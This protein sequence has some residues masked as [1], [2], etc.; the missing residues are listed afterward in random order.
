MFL[1][2]VQSVIEICDAD[3]STCVKGLF[4]IADR[5]PDGALSTAEW[6]RVIRVAI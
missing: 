1:L 2:E 5:H 3:Q 6:S 4:D